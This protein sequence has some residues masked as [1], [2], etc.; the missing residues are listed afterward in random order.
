M[1]EPF[2]GAHRDP[3]G[4]FESVGEAVAAALDQLADIAPESSSRAGTSGCDAIGVFCTP[5]RE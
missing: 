5:T 2:G 3:L 1:P 4:V